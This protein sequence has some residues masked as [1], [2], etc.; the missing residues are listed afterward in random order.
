M[1]K[2]KE[3]DVITVTIYNDNGQRKRVR[4]IILEGLL[5][6][7]KRGQ[8]KEVS[9]LGTPYN[10]NGITEAFGLITTSN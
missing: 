3:V 7:D 8:L 2:N 5:L 1:Q 10:V 6:V 9:T 4:L